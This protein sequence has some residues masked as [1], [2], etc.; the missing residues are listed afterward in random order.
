MLNKMHCTMGNWSDSCKWRT[1]AQKLACTHAHTCTHARMLCMHTHMHNTHTRA[2]THTVLTKIIICHSF[3]AVIS[4]VPTWAFTVWSKVRTRACSSILTGRATDC[5]YETLIEWT[6]CK[7]H[8]PIPV[9]VY[10][11]SYI[12]HLCLR[13][14][15]LC[16]RWDRHSKSSKR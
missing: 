3:L 2:H 6:L 4:C 16:T 1:H 11:C 14:R 8:P 15:L 5:K 10:G 7:F 12:T 9:C 13:R